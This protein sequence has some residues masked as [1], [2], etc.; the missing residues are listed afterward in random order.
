MQNEAELAANIEALITVAHAYLEPPDTAA[1]KA[2]SPKWDLTIAAMPSNLLCVGA[3]E[4]TRECV[5]N[6]KRRDG[7]PAIAHEYS[8]ILY[9]RSLRNLGIEIYREDLVT[10]VTALHDRGEDNGITPPQIRDF[11]RAWAKFHR[12]EFGVKDIE[13]KRLYDDIEI[14]TQEFDTMSRFIP[15]YKDDIGIR[16]YFDDI[17]QSPISSICKAFDRIHNI[18]T[19]EGSQDDA[20]MG[21]KLNE[22]E[23]FF[24]TPIYT[25][26]GQEAPLNYFDAAKILHP[27]NAKAY[28]YLHQLFR[29]ALNIHNA[30]RVNR[31][32]LEK[33]RIA[34]FADVSILVPLPLKEAEMPRVLRPIRGILHREENR[35]PEV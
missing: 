19:L 26:E 25:V 3:L 31:R 17:V 10:V 30:H 32:E 14:I 29:T 16:K 9:P 20:A 22:T 18:Q 2:L 15:G 27:A 34:P 23:L 21:R 8:Q 11:L 5:G 13:L 24:L 33:G 28:D 6:A 1:V 7:S 4:L 35:T 12:D